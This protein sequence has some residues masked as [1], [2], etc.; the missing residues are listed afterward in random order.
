MNTGV[1]VRQRYPDNTK[2]LRVTRTYEKYAQFEAAFT[3]ITHIE[4]GGRDIGQRVEELKY[5]SAKMLEALKGK[6]RVRIPEMRTAE[7]DGES[8]ALLGQGRQSGQ[9]V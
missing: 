2:P 1:S 5:E 7:K 4:N 3:D 9:R 6:Q 8:D